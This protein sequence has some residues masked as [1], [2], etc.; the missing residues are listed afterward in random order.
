MRR[1]MQE[2]VS[3]ARSPAKERR[4]S[5]ADAR[6]RAAARTALPFLLV[7]GLWEMTA[8]LGIFPERLFPPLEAVAS[9]LVR[10]TVAGI[11]PHHA[12]E[13]LLRLL[14]GFWLAAIVGVSLGIAMGRSRLA[15]DVI[16]PL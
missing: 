6:W 4:S 14:A 12:A 13:T 10:R 16:L 7:G 5:G 1:A 8:H 9:A 2:T 3:E 15:E 11:L